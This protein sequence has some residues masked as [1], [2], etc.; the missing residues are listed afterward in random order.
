MYVYRTMTVSIF[1]FL[2]SAPGE[3]LEAPLYFSD[4]LSYSQAFWNRPTKQD[5]HGLN[6][7]PRKH[8]LCLPLQAK[9]TVEHSSSYI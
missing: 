3:I 7:L 1:L 6:Y 2:A 9:P 4:L 5:I 8:N